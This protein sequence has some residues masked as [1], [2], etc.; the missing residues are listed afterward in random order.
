MKV[1]CVKI[2]GILLNIFL[3]NFCIAQVVKT[4]FPINKLSWSHNNEAFSFSEGN[5]IFRNYPL[6]RNK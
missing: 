5:N 3:C 2:S 1:F 6:I 4:P